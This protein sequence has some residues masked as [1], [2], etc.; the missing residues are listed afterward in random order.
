MKE[1]FG[2]LRDI[3]L[4]TPY[5]RSQ[6]LSD[7]WDDEIAET[8]AGFT[9][10]V[11]TIARHLGLSA[12]QLRRPGASLDLPDAQRVQFKLAQGTDANSVQLAR[13]LG[14]RVAR[15]ALLG[16][17]ETELPSL[18]ALDVAS[19]GTLHFYPGPTQ[20]ADL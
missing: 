18:A 12:E 13:V 1:L 3:G 7:W 16:V 4:S 5:V 11:W 2:R 6:I 8:P 14:E 20:S 19:A 17:E 15:F 9:E 10:A